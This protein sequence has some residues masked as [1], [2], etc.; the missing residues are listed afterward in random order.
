MGMTQHFPER[1]ADR[2]PAALA[3]KHRQAGRGNC[4]RA[5]GFKGSG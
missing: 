4:P 3:R 2:K 5:G 1:A